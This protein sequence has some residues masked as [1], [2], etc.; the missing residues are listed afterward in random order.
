MPKDYT[1]NSTKAYHVDKLNTLGWELT[2]CNALHPEGTPL[3]KIITRDD[4]FGHLLYD[5]LGRYMPM[6]KITRV[7]EVG[8]GYGYLMKDFIDR[9]RV[10]RPV[11]L[12]ISP[13]LLRKQKETLREHNVYYVGE[14]FLET[15]PL[16]LT[17]FELAV[18]NEN[19]GDFPVLI[20]LNED[21]FRFS[22]GIADPILRSA[23]HFF[24][25]YGL[26]RPEGVFNL[27]IGALLVLEKLCT[28]GIP[29]IYVG[30]HSCEAAVPEALRPFI[31]I[32]STGN[33]ERIALKGHDEYTI[34]FSYLENIARSFNYRTIRGPFADFISFDLTDELRYMLL[35]QDSASDETE[36]VCQFIDDL[37]RYEYM[38]VIRDTG[39]S[40]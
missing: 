19:L 35:D 23:L 33:P 34:K 24:E 22:S 4:S 40:D 3:R 36:M 5:Y 26:K 21:L 11:M 37:F 9:N 2:V 8:G 32:E 10:I 1:L 38:I 29:Y 7:I 15:D 31:R 39:R 28:A 18:L 30:E 14:D 13:F 27:N 16:F 12:D 6:E 25:K 20:N 17:G